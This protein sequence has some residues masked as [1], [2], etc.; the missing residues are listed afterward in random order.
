MAQTRGVETSIEEMELRLKPVMTMWKS[1]ALTNSNIEEARIQIETVHNA[2]ASIN[3]TI[4][5]LLQKKNVLVK[6][7]TTYF[8]T[9]LK[10]LEL[11][12][13]LYHAQKNGDHLSIY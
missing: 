11:S 10:A 7:P 8:D 12:R 5:T 2:V 3:A 9:M 4:A 6:D 1:V 13:V